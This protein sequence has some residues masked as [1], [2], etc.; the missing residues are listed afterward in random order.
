MYVQLLSKSR[1]VVLFEAENRLGGHALTLQ[2]VD[3]GFQVY[4]LT[5]YPYLQAIFDEL[6]V[7]TEPSEMSFSFSRKGG[8][9]W[10]SHGPLSLLAD[11][12]NAISPSFWIMFY[13]A[14]RFAKVAQVTLGPDYDVKITL[15]EFLQEHGF[16]KSFADNYLLPMTAAVWSV[17]NAQMLDYPVQA[18][19]RF[20]HN[21][22]LLN[23]AGAR[24]RWRVCKHRS[25]AYVKAIE[26]AL[27]ANGTE[28]LT[29]TPVTRVQRQNEFV[30]IG[31]GAQQTKRVQH[32]V[33]ATHAPTT[34]RILGDDVSPE[35]LCVL[36]NVK[37]EPNHIVLHSDVRLMPVSRRAWASWNV[38]QTEQSNNQD[39]ICVTYW[40][41]R[42]QNLATGSP[43]RLC[44][45]NPCM[46]IS[47]DAIT[48]ELKL[49]HP[50]FDVPA[51][52]AQQQIISMQADANPDSQRTWF[53][54]AWLGSGFH[55]DGVRAA[56]AVAAK[57]G[58]QPSWARS[59]PSVLFHPHERGPD[60]ESPTILAQIGLF[61]FDSMAKS[62]LRRGFL[63]IVMPSGE[64]LV[65]G[66]ATM[67]AALALKEPT[68]EMRVRDTSMFV[69]LMAETDIALGEAY[70]RKSF[71]MPRGDED[72]KSLLDFLILN[73]Q[74]CMN[75]LSR[76]GVLFPLSNLASI[77]FW[78]GNLIGRFKHALRDNTVAGSR[79]NIQEHYDIG[80]NLYELFL[81]NDTWGYSAGIHEHPGVS[82]KDAQLAKVCIFVCCWNP[83]RY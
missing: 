18:L 37:Y 1:K 62:A 3:L 41:N 5:T 57:L 53:A 80:N 11:P 64:E 12:M 61:A 45:L 31:Y 28:I 20:W 56:V 79:Q 33:F 24:P 66:R 81:D 67:S 22:H 19:V 4:N 83:V 17:P 47:Q 82:L 43:L 9:E 68:C 76:F 78:I 71:T 25:D 46:P 75:Q 23:P 42:L 26:K 50:V 34:L 15:R 39:Q 14:F 70:F 7:E 29:G 36:R 55:E 54:G 30:D 21:H 6:Q 72:L 48:L 52:L 35:E 74:N 77:M 32:V 13:E 58:C 44:T 2:G 40:L 65:Y 49:E 59:T 8:M 69:K 38:L 10:G 73:R 51:L 63:R 60:P 16:S 27:L